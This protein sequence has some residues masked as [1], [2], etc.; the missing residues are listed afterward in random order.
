ME[1]S[2]ASERRVGRNPLV[3]TILASNPPVE[4]S[5]VKYPGPELPVAV[6]KYLNARYVI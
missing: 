2:Q 1:H 4:K 3:M 6:E 5:S